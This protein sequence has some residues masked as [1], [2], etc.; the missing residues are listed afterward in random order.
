ML[1]L[2]RERVSVLRIERSES[3]IEKGALRSLHLISV[4]PCRCA[5]QR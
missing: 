5:A 2:F 3:D 4:A 1:R